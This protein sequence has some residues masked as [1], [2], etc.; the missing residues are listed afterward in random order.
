MSYDPDAPY[1][2]QRS[3]SDAL[4]S[5]VRTDQPHAIDVLESIDRAADMRAAFLNRKIKIENDKN[6]S[7]A[8]RQGKI[9]ELAREMMKDAAR[10]G[11]R[12]RKALGHAASARAA[13]MEPT[14][15]DPTDAVGE[16][17]RQEVR[18]YMRG[19]KP[20]ERQSFAQSLI[21]DEMGR[22]AIL[23]APPAMTGLDQHFYKMLRE[24]VAEHVN[25]PQLRALEGVADDYGLAKQVSDTFRRELF[26]E[27]GLTQTAFDEQMTTLEAEADR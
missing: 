16:L 22:A 6:L 10:V 8:G 20:H 27:S 2:A 24:Q 13:L 23:D 1:R 25:G 7:T 9:A 3:M 17:R 26:K 12:P 19:L 14:K 15:V 5:N 21:G 4:K 11:S 18:A